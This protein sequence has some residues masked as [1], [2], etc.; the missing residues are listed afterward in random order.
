[1]KMNYN[2]A[3]Y[4]VFISNCLLFISCGEKLHTTIGY[5]KNNTK[6]DLVCANWYKSMADSSLCNNRINL[7]TY[8]QPNLGNVLTTGGDRN[9]NN[10]PD[11]SIEYIYIFNKDSLDKYQEL[12]ICE[13]IV[14][15][16]LVKKI[17][18]QL[19]KVKEPMDTV[20]INSSKV[21]N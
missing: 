20:F 16:C 1:M 6:S 9:L 21:L 7:N 4:L 12:K 15:R 8:L 17:E 3:V 5:I 14:K 19:N 11:S 2:I 13:G 10:E 18:I